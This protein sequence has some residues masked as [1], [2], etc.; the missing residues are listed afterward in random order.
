MPLNI[1]VYSK[2]LKYENSIVIY[3]IYIEFLKLVV[4]IQDVDLEN[5]NKNKSLINYVLYITSKGIVLDE[6]DF[7]II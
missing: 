3:I 2:I 7:K 4:Y 5:L 1:K 6:H